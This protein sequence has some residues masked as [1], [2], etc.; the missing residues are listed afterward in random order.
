VKRADLL[1]M[2]GL[3]PIAAV[4]ARALPAVTKAEPM[5]LRT[6]IAGTAM[7]GRGIALARAVEAKPEYDRFEILAK[8]GTSIFQAPLREGIV[9][10][11][12][13]TLAHAGWIAQ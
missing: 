9:P 8:D 11:G 6:G 10:R 1:R 5:A 12:W 13:D 7:L 3:A 2:I 4:A